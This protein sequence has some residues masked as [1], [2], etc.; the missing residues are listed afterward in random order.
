MTARRCGVLGHPVSHSLSPLLHRTAYAELGLDWTYVAHD[1]TA[2]GLAD[3]V[4]ALDLTWRGLSLTMPLKRAVLPLLDELDDTARAAGAVNTVL[5]EDGRRLGFNTDVGGLV[6]ALRATG[7]LPRGRA[8]VL[9]SGATA[10]SVLAALAALGVPSAVLRVR[11]EGRAE[12][13]VR[14]GVG[15][16]LDVVVARLDDPWPDE[17]GLLVS[18]VPSAVAAA[19]VP[20][21]AL[22]EVVGD[23]AYDPWPSPLLVRAAQLG[24]RTASGL[25]LLVHQAV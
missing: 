21:T 19:L 16:G 4:S 15:L 22:R 6:A 9:G 23:V 18:T 17:P 3:F 13:T 2:D 14:A 11:D 8:V 20:D 24:A 5:L 7:D 25:D 12:V 1:V 10:A